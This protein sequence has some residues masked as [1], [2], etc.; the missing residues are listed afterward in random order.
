MLP[1]CTDKPGGCNHDLCIWIRTQDRIRELKGQ[2]SA[3]QYKQIYRNIF[4]PR[5][6]RLL[7][8]LIELRR[9]EAAKRE[10][11]ADVAL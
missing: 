7:R 9:E 4:S 2:C 6:P 11:K 8:Y 1:P 10:Q 5:N 3:E